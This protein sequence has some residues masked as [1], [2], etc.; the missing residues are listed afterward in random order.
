MEQFTSIKVE[1]YISGSW[2][3]LTPDVIFPIRGFYGIS[4]STFMGRVADVGTLSF[5]LDNSEK[6]SVTTLGYYSPEHA[7]TLTGWQSGLPVRLE[8]KYDGNTVYDRYYINV[9]GI[10]IT[11]GIYGMRRV[12][13]TCS[14]W[15]RYASDWILDLMASQSNQ[16][17]NEA[18]QL[19]LD[20]MPIPPQGYTYQT[21][22][23]QFATVFDTSSNFTTALGEFQ[24]L[25]MSEWG[26]VVRLRDGIRGETLYFTSRAGGD[27]YGD[28]E[29]VGFGAIP[30]YSTDAGFFLLADNSS[31]LLLADNASKLVL[32]QFQTITFSDADYDTTLQPVITHGRQT[33]NSC[34]IQTYPRKLDAAA[35]TVL[36]TMENSLEIAPGATKTDI[37]G[38]YRDPNGQ[39]EKINGVDFV[40][41][42]ANTDYKAY[43]NAN[44]TGTDLTANLSVNVTFGAA[45]AE[46]TLENTGGTTLYTGGD[47]LFQVRGRGVYVYDKTDITQ[48]DETSIQQYGK[49]EIVIPWQYSDELN[50]AVLLASDIVSAQDFKTPHTYLERVS[51]T[52][53]RN[54]KNMLVFMYAS[55]PAVYQFSETMS[56][57]SDVQYN[58]QG[59]EFEIGATNLVRF[60]FILTKFFTVVDF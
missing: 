9:D 47:I 34:T 2:V 29:G 8:Y 52:A 49:H 56:G 50:N 27:K 26:R 45:E 4:D 16:R 35:N 41:P 53:N 43:A 19:V 32:G 24:K 23:S 39:S 14:D 13:V 36:W 60:S 38:R 40:T 51:F 6:N 10:Q 46:I 3:D 59:I 1:V 7:N 31:H 33:V 11:S 5:Q 28:V 25:A 12:N 55:P 48:E 58:V 18:I 37:R 42:V 44:G 17:P 21:G 15:M 22:T 20:N 30:E 57:T 54:A